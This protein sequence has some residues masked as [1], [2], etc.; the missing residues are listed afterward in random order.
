[1]EYEDEFDDEFGRLFYIF[2]NKFYLIK[3]FV[4]DENVLMP[5]DE[6]EEEEEW[7]DDQEGN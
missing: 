2:L 5:E 7:E 6:D 3:K 4:E 1:L